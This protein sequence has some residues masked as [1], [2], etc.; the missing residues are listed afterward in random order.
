MHVLGLLETRIAVCVLVVQ[1]L[2]NW[3][4]II[5]NLFSRMK[6][7]TF[8]W[9]GGEY[10]LYIRLVHKRLDYRQSTGGREG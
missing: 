8:F 1:L 6:Y 5:C 7:Y 4:D 10:F 3:G 9:G 2:Q